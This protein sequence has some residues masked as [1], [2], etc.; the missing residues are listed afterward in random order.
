M[1]SLFNIN[2]C[3]VDEV[4]WSW[5]EYLNERYNVCMHAMMK[6]QYNRT[7]HIPADISSELCCKWR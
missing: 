6:G 2:N 1:I 7:V 4:Y 3:K 5:I